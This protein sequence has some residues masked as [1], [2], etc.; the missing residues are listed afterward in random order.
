MQMEGTKLYK[1]T[2]KILKREGFK[3]FYKGIGGPI[4]SVPALNAVVFSSYETTRK[5]FEVQGR[6]GYVESK[7]PP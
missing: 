1:T 5:Y 2:M 3:G 4:T 6:D 7:F